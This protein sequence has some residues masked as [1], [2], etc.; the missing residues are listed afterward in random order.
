MR[1]QMIL[2]T[3]A[4]S[5]NRGLFR[6]QIVTA[7][8]RYFLF[9]T[10]GPWR[11]FVWP[12]VLWHRQY[13]VQV[14]TQQE[15]SMLQKLPPTSNRVLQ[16]HHFV[17][18]TAA[19]LGLVL[20]FIGLAAV[21][22]PMGLRLLQVLVI[23]TLLVAVA[24]DWQLP[25]AQEQALRELLPGQVAPT[26]YLRLAPTSFL[27]RSGLVLLALV[28]ILLVGWSSVQIVTSGSMYW[29][30]VMV[31]SLLALLGSPRWYLR[32]GVYTVQFT[33]QL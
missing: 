4:I 29:W 23:W 32:Y 10:T 8:G 12:F 3:P 15:W 27:R 18:G 30:L 20:L 16:R 7:N 6:Y 13:P 2:N 24:V 25:F 14:L 21:K 31:V 26:L 9:D 19:C 11:Q 5:T 22:L 28:I 17:D 33:G 1:Y